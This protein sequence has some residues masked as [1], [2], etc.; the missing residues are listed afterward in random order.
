MLQGHTQPLPA[1][2]VRDEGLFEVALPIISETAPAPSS[3][4]LRYKTE[5]GEAFEHYDAYAFPYLLSE[6]DLYLMGEG[7]HYDTYEKLGAHIRTV[8]GIAGVHYAVWA[9]SARRVSVVGDFNGWDGRVHPMRARGSSGIWELFV[10]ELGEGTV[11]KFEIVGPQD[12]ILPLKADPYAFAAE[13]RHNTGSVVAR[14]D[15]HHWNDNEWMAQRP[16]K[17]WLERPVCVYEVHLGSW[18]RVAEENDR[19]LSYAAL[20]D[21]LIPYVKDL[22]F[23]HIERSRSWSIPTTAPGVT[24]RLATSLPPADTGHRA[25]SWS[26]SIAA[27]SQGS[28][29]SSIGLPRIFRVTRMA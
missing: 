27:T 20:A 19:W 2:K 23:T 4:R 14:L 18:R 24:K 21:Q 8:D 26:S 28:E 9:P 15:K 3:Y 16:H 1:R 6:F 10:P 12:N 7:R 11:Y 25:I 22:G 5:Y 13:L 29:F 17:H